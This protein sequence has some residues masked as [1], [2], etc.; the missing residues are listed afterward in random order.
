MIEIATPRTEATSVATP[1]EATKHGIQNPQAHG[2]R[3]TR[4]QRRHRRQIASQ[5]RKMEGNPTNLSASKVNSD[6]PQS[7]GKSNHVDTQTTTAARRKKPPPRPKAGKSG[8][9]SRP[10]TTTLT[11]EAAT[12]SQ[13]LDNEDDEEN[14]QEFIKSMY[15][16]ID[17]LNKVFHEDS[18]HQDGKYCPEACCEQQ[19]TTWWYRAQD[20]ADEQEGLPATSPLSAGTNKNVV[21]NTAT[22]LSLI[23]I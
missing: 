16:F 14:L 13:D 17:R 23:H 3:K 22:T 4:I 11:K 21:I 1:E 18:V 5:G 15:R 9:P 20:F 2:G 19:I 7:T 8:K 10:A 12:P 6:P